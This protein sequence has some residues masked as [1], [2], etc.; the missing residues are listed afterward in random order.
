M[1]E[2][3]ENC[4]HNPAMGSMWV[5]RGFDEKIPHVAVQ[6]TYFF[7]LTIMQIFP[8]AQAGAADGQSSY[9]SEGSEGKNW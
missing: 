4:R 6:H 9:Y 5:G 8:V 3:A 2:V 7:L 1:A